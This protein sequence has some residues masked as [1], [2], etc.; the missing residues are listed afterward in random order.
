MKKIYYTLA[1][2]LLLPAILLSTI[3]E[4]KQFDDLLNHLNNAPAKVMVVCDID[5]TLIMPVQHLG[6]VAWGEHMM[7]SLINKGIPPQQV[8][9]IGNIL[10]KL[11]QARIAVTTVDPNTSSII[12]QIKDRGI[13]VLGL[14]A[15][16]VEESVYTPSQLKSVDII[17]SGQPGLPASTQHYEWE[18]PSLYD[19]GILY[20]TPYNRKSES[21]L[22]FLAHNEIQLEFL[23]FIDDKQHH[24][25][26]VESACKAQGIECFALRYGAA[27]H[28]MQL[29]DPAIADIQ[30]KAFPAILSNEEARKRLKEK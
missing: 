2:T 6:T 25:E 10:W 22:A 27:D 7:A 5:N 17:L 14:T 21:L 18:I 1:A 24:V 8:E 15:R 19:N 23:I 28:H 13:P 4:T 29:F 16:E 12:K 20:V 9:E 30:W 11:V 26:D 3:T